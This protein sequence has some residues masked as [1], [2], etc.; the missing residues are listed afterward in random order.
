MPKRTANAV[1]KGTLKEGSGTMSFADYEGPFTRMSRFEEGEGTNPEELVGAAH[2]GCYSMFL[3][4][5]LSSAGYTPT[6]I[7]TTAT[8]HL[9]R[10]NKGPLITLIELDV[11]ADVPGI[12]ADKFDVSIC[13]NELHASLMKG[14]EAPFAWV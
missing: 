9:G 13:K 7:K 4:A 8:V 6:S 12:D 11:T 10:D 14:T 5:Q 2:A 3:S 1:W